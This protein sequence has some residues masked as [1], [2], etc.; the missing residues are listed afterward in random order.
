V[1]RKDDLPDGESE[2]L[3]DGLIRRRHVDQPN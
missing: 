1:N 3:P 2:I